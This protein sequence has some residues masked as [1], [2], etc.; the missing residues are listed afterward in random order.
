MVFEILP[1]GFSKATAIEA[2]SRRAPF[3][4]RRPIMIGDDVGD[5]PAFDYARRAG[6]LALRVAGE[7]F[8]LE[9]SELVSPNAVRA[10]LDKLVSTTSNA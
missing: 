7:H 2:L 10:F 8:P 9:D 6:G 4:G 5:L 1:T 3:A